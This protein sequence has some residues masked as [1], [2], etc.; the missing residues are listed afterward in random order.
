MQ[1]PSVNTGRRRFLAQSAA[2]GASLLIGLRI[3]E[4]GAAT[5]VGAAAP[6]PGPDA[7]E[8]TAWVRIE[9]SGEIALIVSQAEIGQGISTTLPAVLADELGADWSRVRLL[10]APW[11]PEYRHPRYDWMFTGNSESIQ[12]FYAH[13][14]RM[15]AAA[16]EMLITAAAARW[17]VPLSQCRSENSFIVHA[18]SGRRLAFA[19]LAREAA[20]LPVPTSPVLRPDK[21][22]KLVGRALPRVDAPAKTTGRAVFGIDFAV[23]GMLVAAVRTAPPIGAKLVGYDAGTAPTMPGMRAVLPIANGVA[24]VAQKYWQAARALREVKLRVEATDASRQADSAVIDAQ[25]DKA[26]EEGPWAD[27]VSEGTPSD[28]GDVITA[29]YANPFAAHATMEPMNCVAQVSATRCEIWAP[30]QGQ[31]LARIALQYALGLPPEQ[32]FVNRTPYIGGGFGRRLVPDFIVQAALIAKAVGAP[33]KVIWDREEDVRRDLFR[34]A[35]RVRLAARTDEQGLPIELQ[36]RVVSPTILLP[37][38]PPIQKTLDEQGFDPSAMEGLMHVPYKFSARRVQ[39]HLPRISVP[40][41]VMRTTGYGP[42]LFALESFVDELAA[43]AKQDP[44]DFRRRLLQH[45]AHAL[46]LLDRLAA[47]SQWGRPQPRGRA[48]GLAFADAFGTLIG[49]VVELAQRDA[50]VHLTRI[51]TVVDCGPVLDPG[52]ARAGI[53]GGIV[54]GMAYCKAE[55]SF[56]HGIVRQDNLSTHV[57]PYLAETPE[58]AIEFMRSERPLGG[59][60]EVSPVTVPPAIANALFAASGRRLRSMPLA[61]HGLHFV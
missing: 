29:S 9:R 53:E 25:L 15:G 37:V 45:D 30:T 43:R 46:A 60:G 26:L 35:T 34:P 39:F 5:L 3:D 50:A 48:R 57:M 28:A 33:V 8:L 6:Q 14:R 31:D 18:A 16:R 61:R 56:D 7:V 38:F 21:E 59:V 58:M 41:S 32:I 13:M 27:V 42:N 20:A 11:R 19:A 2:A 52:I 54:F 36:A 4:A 44:L 1:F 49:M 51:S 22:L 23:P 10:T 47:L 55:L 40:T 12:S 17:R 24:V